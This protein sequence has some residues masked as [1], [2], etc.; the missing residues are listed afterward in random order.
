MTPRFAAKHDVRALLSDD[1]GITLTELMVAVMLMTVVSVIFTSV[2]AS[3]TMATR[4]LQGAVTS[5]DTV[6]LVLQTLDAELRSAER[7]CTPAPGD[8]GNTLE[9][10]TRSYVKNPPASGYRDIIYQLNADDDDDLTVLEKSE[11]GGTT[12][13]TVVDHV[14]NDALAVDLF[15]NQGDAATAL[16]SQGKVITIHVWSDA[17]PNDRVSAELATTEISGR[18]IWTP[19]AAG[20]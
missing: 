10:R 17:N 3:S 18:N 13:R 5:N 6:R 1:H 19:N 14:E 7:V 12:W 4:D 11:D 8:S 2:L 16:P 9:F 20:C 15:E